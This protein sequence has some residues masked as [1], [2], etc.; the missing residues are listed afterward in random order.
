MTS[1]SPY[2]PFADLRPVRRCVQCGSLFRQKPMTTGRFCRPRCWY[3]NRQVKAYRGVPACGTC[4]GPIDPSDGI[5][6]RRKFCSRAC[7]DS[8]LAKQRSSSPPP[9]VEGARWL[10]LTRGKFALVDADLFESLLS[11]PWVAGRIPQHSRCDGTPKQLHR[12]IIG[13][14]DPAILVDHRNGDPLDNRRQNLRVASHA[15]NLQ[16]A[17]K[18]R[19][20]RT[21]QY[22]GVHLQT[23]QGRKKWQVMIRAPGRARW[24]G[25]FE[26][27]EEAARAYDIAARDAFGEFAC[28]NFPKEGERCAI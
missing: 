21:S 17:K 15:Q 13:I 25:G 27:E 26:T 18:K 14:R 6:K 23:K 16:N 1:Q 11:R 22:K 20:A 28:V 19:N 9:H 8:A 12:F 10:P 2:Q 5:R 4:G 24:V 3:D 7:A